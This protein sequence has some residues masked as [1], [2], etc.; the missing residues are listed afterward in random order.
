MPKGSEW[1][2][3]GSNCLRSW[4]GLLCG[5]VGIGVGEAGG[6]EAAL[7]PSRTCLARCQIPIGT[8]A[9]GPLFVV[10]LYCPGNT[11][12][13]PHP[14]PRAP[15]A[16]FRTSPKLSP[17]ANPTKRRAGR[18]NNSPARRRRRATSPSYGSTCFAASS[19]A[20]RAGAPR[21]GSARSAKSPTTAARPDVPNRMPLFGI[22][23][24]SEHN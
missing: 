24:R 15:R 7:R 6:K 4:P 19:A 20:R 16:P 17:A 13:M 23:I 10:A 3:R 5:G 1:Q 21:C 12:A 2:N 11:Q 22:I 8:R 14:P 9:G 18:R